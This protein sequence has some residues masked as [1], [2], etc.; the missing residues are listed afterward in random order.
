VHQLF[1][2]RKAVD[3]I[4]EQGLEAIWARHR[5]MA[6]ATRAAVAAWAADGPLE[7]NVLE[8]SERSDSVTTILAPGVDV[9]AFRALCQNELGLV[10][11]IGLGAMGES[12]FRIGHMGWLNAPMLMGAL[13]AAQAGLAACGIAHGAG[14]L[15]AAAQVLATALREG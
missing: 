11:G 10:L 5:A 8:P 15:E 4:E 2:L 12:A 14:G 1:G 9:A 7:F 13:G 3:L 6:A